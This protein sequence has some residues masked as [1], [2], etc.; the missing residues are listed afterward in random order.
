MGSFEGK[1]GPN[2]G[3]RVARDSAQIAAEMTRACI[4][5]C[6]SERERERE[7]AHPRAREGECGYHDS[8]L[9]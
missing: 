8:N 7:R 5:I 9:N 4:C 3:R 1:S 2:A 6:A